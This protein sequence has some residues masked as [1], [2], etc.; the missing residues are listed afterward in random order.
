M[1]KRAR[2]T[3]GLHPPVHDAYIHQLSL[4]H[5]DATLTQSLQGCNAA[6]GSSSRTPS[7]P[8]SSDSTRSG[9]C[10][11]MPRPT[12]VTASVLSVCQSAREPPH[13]HPRIDSA[14]AR[15]P[16]HSSDGSRSSTFVRVRCPFAPPPVRPTTR[17][18]VLSPASAP[19]PT[20][21][22]APNPDHPPALTL[23]QDTVDISFRAHLSRS[24]R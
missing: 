10:I 8:V 13:E 14:A 21:R 9:N 20:T 6:A 11:W 22:P 5:P 3:D 24:L 4:A 12:L 18:R 7:P 2:R 23:A 15:Q 16:A 19:V 17:P 1:R